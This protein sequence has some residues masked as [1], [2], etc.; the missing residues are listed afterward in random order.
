M[1]GSD[2][3]MLRAR[4]NPSLVSMVLS[5]EEQVLARMGSFRFTMKQ[6][7][8]NEL[9]TTEILPPAQACQGLL[10]TYPVIFVPALTGLGR[11]APLHPSRRA[12]PAGPDM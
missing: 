12:H 10:A 5:S 3:R 1:S 7:H 2:V 4:T 11:K 9:R 6:N 8:T